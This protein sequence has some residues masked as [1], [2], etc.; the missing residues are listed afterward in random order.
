MHI[1]VHVNQSTAH[2]LVCRYAL[3][4]CIGASALLAI[5]Q[6]IS[7]VTSLTIANLN[8]GTGYMVSRSFH[9]FICVVAYKKQLLAFG[10]GLLFWQPMALQYGKRPVYLASTLGTIV[11]RTC[12]TKCDGN[13]N[14]K[15][16]GHDL[17]SAYHQQ[18]SMDSEQNLAGIFRCSC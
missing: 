18:C 2:S 6:P 5:L 3:C 14:E 11:L 1:L 12:T 15:I 4:I 16:G 7:E 9:R 13:A 17:D 10:W 8:E